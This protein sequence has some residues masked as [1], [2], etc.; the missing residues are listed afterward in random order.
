V[1][2]KNLLL[3]QLWIRIR[4]PLNLRAKVYL[5][6]SLITLSHCNI[7]NCKS[8]FLKVPCG[9]SEKFVYQMVTT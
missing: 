4:I 9:L 1:K 6:T 7:R 5:D 8:H 2:S 3:L